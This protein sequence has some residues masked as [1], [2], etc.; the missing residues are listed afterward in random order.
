MVWYRA[1]LEHLDDLHATAAA[2]A[3]MLGLVGRCRGVRTCSMNRLMNSR[4]AVT[5]SAT[6]SDTR[7]PA[8]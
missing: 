6:T 7:N 5:F 3:G 8:P 4:G 1:S 2:R